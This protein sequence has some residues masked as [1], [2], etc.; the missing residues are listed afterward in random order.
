M[1]SRDAAYDD[2]EEFRRILENSKKEAGA[3]STDNGVRRNKR[4]RSDSEE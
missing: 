4:G 2:T 3:P 1:N